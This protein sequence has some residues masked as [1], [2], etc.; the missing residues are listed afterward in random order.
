[1]KVTTHQQK[2]SSAQAGSCVSGAFIEMALLT[3]SQFETEL[4]FTYPV[5]TILCAMVPLTLCTQVISSTLFSINLF[6]IADYKVRY[7]TVPLSENFCC[8]LYLC[9]ILANYGND[10]CLVSLVASYLFMLRL[11]IRP[12]FDLCCIVRPNKRD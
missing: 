3:D 10:T 2:F 12:N 8:K 6:H 5:M 4:L 1:M 9:K 11:T 7:S